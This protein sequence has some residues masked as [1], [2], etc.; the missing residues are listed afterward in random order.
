MAAMPVPPLVLAAQEPVHARHEALGVDRRPHLRIVVEIDEHVA[1]AALGSGLA[2]RTL[3]IGR[4]SSTRPGG[5]AHGPG[6]ERS[7]VVAAGIEHL[8]TVQPAI[9]E[10]R[11]EIHEPRPLHRVGTDERNTVH[12]QVI[13]EGRRYEALVAYLQGVAQSAFCVDLRPGAAVQP[14]IVPPG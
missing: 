12:A 11:S 10:V 7:V 4:F 3:G 9:D 2:E 8:R 14:F 5:G 1:A 6:V 13:D